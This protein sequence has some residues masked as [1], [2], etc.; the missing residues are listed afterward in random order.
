MCG[1]VTEVTSQHDA[2]ACGVSVITA[3]FSG[4]LLLEA[5]TS[6]HIECTAGVDRFQ[7]FYYTSLTM[8]G[9]STCK[10]SMLLR[11]HPALA[12][13]TAG[14]PLKHVFCQNSLYGA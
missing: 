12:L 8:L 2:A 1:V 14:V 3:I 9:V 5:D 6:A 7:A 10:A 4:L 11:S 13:H